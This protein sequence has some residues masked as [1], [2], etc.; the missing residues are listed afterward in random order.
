MGKFEQAIPKTINTLERELR[1]KRSEVWAI[2]R[3]YL[4]DCDCSHCSDQQ[5]ELPPDQQEVVDELEKD[6][7]DIDLT[8][9]RLKRHAKANNIEVK[10]EQ[11]RKLYAGTAV[12][13]G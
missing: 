7:E 4:H 3:E 11:Y 13:R 6:I 10:H 2:E 8:I 12:A 1:A 9:N 5:Y